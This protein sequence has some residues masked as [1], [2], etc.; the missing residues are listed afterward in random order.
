VKPI[1][2]PKACPHCRS[3]RA[4]RSHR[5]SSLERLLFALGAEIR[6]CRDCH[7]RHAAFGSLAIP[8]AGH[9]AAVEHAVSKHVSKHV[10]KQWTS[11]AVLG[12]GLV[13]V[14]VLWAIRHFVE[15]PG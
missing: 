15:S 11:A 12:S 7:F 3:T 2:V 6:R 8:L 4:Q 10:S 13:I 5:R 1:P 9:P 14:L